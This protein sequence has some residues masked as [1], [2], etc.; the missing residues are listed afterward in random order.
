MSTARYS[1]NVYDE[2]F[3][4]VKTLEA[5][6]IRWGTLVDVFEKLTSEDA[7]N[8]AQAVEDL[9]LSIFPTATRED[10]RGCMLE[11]MTAIVAQAASLGARNGLTSKAKAVKGGKA[12]N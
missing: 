4:I 6:G 9:M 10:L 1:L 12:K 7:E 3:E 2:D 11:D 5:P 8:D